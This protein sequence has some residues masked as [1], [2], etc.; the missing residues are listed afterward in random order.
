M[1]VLVI[2]SAGGIGGAEKNLCKLSKN[3]SNKIN[4]N[5][6]TLKSHGEIFEYFSD[7]G[8]V[9]VNKKITSIPIL[10]IIGEF[11]TELNL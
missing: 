11:I 10:K 3:N 2:F 7:L 5:F 6:Y 1:K 4:Y 8:I 9:P